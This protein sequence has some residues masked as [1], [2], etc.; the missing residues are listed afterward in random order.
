M[1]R[2][3]L[4]LARPLPAGVRYFA[5]ASGEL[6]KTPLHSA[7]TA[8]GAKM[9]GF[10]GWDMP[11]QQLSWG[12]RRPNHNS[13][14]ANAW[15]S[16]RRRWASCLRA[17]RRGCGPGT[18]VHHARLVAR[19]APASSVEA[20][21]GPIPARAQVPR[22]H[23]EEPHVHA[24]ERRPLR[25]LAHARRDRARQGPRGLHGVALRGRHRGP[26]FELMWRASHRHVLTVQRTHPARGQSERSPRRAPRRTR[27]GASG[28]SRPSTF[29]TTRCCERPAP[30]AD[31]SSPLTPP[32]LC[33]RGWGVSLC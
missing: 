13:A 11:I 8:L 10:G 21:S 4:Q 24:R 3:R 28:P 30:H 33:P 32:Q 14:A 5:A 23:H 16:L 6:R 15:L 7:H 20:A 19:N 9:A 17:A 26:A 18:R 2:M 22:R 27:R 1:M 12:R 29:C 25:R 31:F